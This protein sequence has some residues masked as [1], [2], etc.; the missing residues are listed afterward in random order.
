MVMWVPKIMMG[1]LHVEL[2]KFTA[3]KSKISEE[4]LVM[5]NMKS[6]S[7]FVTKFCD[8]RIFRR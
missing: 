1:N 7:N 5:K 6:L 3:K 2:G 8:Q 4:N